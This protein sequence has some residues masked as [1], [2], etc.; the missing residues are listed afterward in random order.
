MITS[1]QI[2]TPFEWPEF[3]SHR[4]RIRHNT[5]HF[6]DLSFYEIFT[7]HKKNK[8]T[9]P[10]IMPGQLHVGQIIP[11][12][13]REISKRGVNIDPGNWKYDFICANRLWDYKKFHEFI[14][15]GKINA[16]VTEITRNRATVDFIMPRLREFINPR[17]ERPWIQNDLL[18]AEPITVTVTDLFETRGGFIG[19]AIIPN[20]SEWVGEPFTIP[21]FVPGS[22]L[23]LNKTN[24][25]E[26]FLGTTLRTF[27][28]SV[29]GRAGNTN[30]LICSAR[31]VENFIGWKNLLRI[32]NAWCD[33]TE[34]WKSI[35]DTHFMGIITGKIN[36]EQRRGVF[37]EI[38]E[39][40]ITG[41]V[42]IPMDNSEIVLEKNYIPGNDVSVRITDILMPTHYDE[43][44]EQNVHDEPFIIDE[45]RYIK[46]VSLRPVL[47]FAE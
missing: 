19:N 35:T 7:G 15:T 28:T 8:D 40:K 24:N 41:L 34:E 30:R 27:I 26:S 4:D 47:V 45:G 14:P 23:A 38:P 6:K 9:E 33:D 44:F 22:Q 17:L 21:A 10:E 11:L 25:F 36:S 16:Q 5:E 2:E 39:L 37:V 12:Q 43:A 1:N 20:I 3:N 42:S 18:A 32:Y 29:S 13:I 46:K 31:M